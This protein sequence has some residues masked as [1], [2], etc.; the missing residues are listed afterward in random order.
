MFNDFFFHRSFLRHLISLEKKTFKKKI[1]KCAEWKRK[2]FPHIWHGRDDENTGFLLI[3]LTKTGSIFFFAL[4][5]SFCGG[6]RA[7]T[8]KRD[9][10]VIGISSQ[11][12]LRFL[13]IYRYHKKSKTKKFKN[14]VFY[15][16][17]LCLPP[18]RC[19]STPPDTY[20]QDR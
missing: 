6:G 15:I 14:F 20:A 11:F 16:I 13:C 8:K 18:S 17:K 5:I 7:T 10:K 1:E 19:F 3:K 9:D 2:K 4:L 12:N